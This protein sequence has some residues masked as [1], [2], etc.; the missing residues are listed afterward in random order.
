MNYKNYGLVM[1]DLGD[2]AILHLNYELHRLVI[3][4]FGDDAVNHMDYEKLG[5]SRKTYSTWTTKNIV[6]K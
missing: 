2:D 5:R 1:I 6:W 3:K 4:H